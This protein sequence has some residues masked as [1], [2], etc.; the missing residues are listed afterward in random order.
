MVL[1]PHIKT[2]LRRR[3]VGITAVGGRIARTQGQ[4]EAI[5]FAAINVR[6]IR[7]VSKDCWKMMSEWMK[8]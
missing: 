3:V 1:A 8:D 2:V 7:D 4:Q 6:G 5:Q